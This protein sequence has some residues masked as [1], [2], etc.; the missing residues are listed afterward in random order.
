MPT[1]EYKCTECE[2]T[3][4]AFQKMNDEPLKECPEC[5]SRI[6]RLIGSGAGI[7]FKGEGFHVNDYS[8]D[9]AKTSAPPCCGGGSCPHEK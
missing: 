1:Y 6:K 2:H 7:I 5:G 9:K 4:E 3:F 8:N